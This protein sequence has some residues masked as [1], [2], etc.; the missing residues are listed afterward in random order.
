[1]RVKRLRKGT[2]LDSLASFGDSGMFLND[3]IN[4]EDYMAS[5]KLKKKEK[6]K[7]NIY[8]FFKHSICN[9]YLIFKRE[10][11]KGKR[12]KTKNKIHL[13]LIKARNL[14]FIFSSSCC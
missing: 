14:N 11:K 3:N 9:Y 13:N 7:K 8:I 4:M 2:N 12:K 5:K 1:M 10:R 6:S